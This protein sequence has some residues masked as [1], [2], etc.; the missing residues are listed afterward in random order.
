M[1]VLFIRIIL[2]L[3][4]FN[5]GRGIWGRVYKFLVDITDPF[6]II[7]RKII[8]II[9]MGRTY[10]DL[11]Y[12]AAKKNQTYN[13]F[14]EELFSMEQFL[15]FSSNAIGF[16]MPK[17]VTSPEFMKNIF[18]IAQTELLKRNIAALN[19]KVKLN[20]NL[21]NTVLRENGFDTQ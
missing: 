20:S 21:T 11:S 3:L 17:I 16:T 1:Y 18:T 9:R 12:I 15:K 7:F 5:P 2:S 14:P 13:I 6:L 19:L 4:R 8:P 10:L